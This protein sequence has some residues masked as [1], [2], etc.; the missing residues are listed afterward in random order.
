MRRKAIRRWH[1]LKDEAFPRVPG[2]DEDDHGASQEMPPQ[3]GGIYAPAANLLLSSTFDSL[4]A[5]D[6]KRREPETPAEEEQVG[7]VTADAFRP[8]QVAHWRLHEDR[9][10]QGLGWLGSK[11][12]L[13]WP[14]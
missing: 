7:V 13:A 1:L 11:A 14:R 8:L 5:A 6:S 2:C 12:G 4:T 3:L 9:G 10:E